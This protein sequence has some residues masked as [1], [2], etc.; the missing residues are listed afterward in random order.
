MIIH[1]SRI[2][3]R[4]CKSIVPN[5]PSV[6]AGTITPAQALDEC[7]KSRI[8]NYISEPCK[9]ACAVSPEDM[10]RLLAPGVRKAELSA[11]AVMALCL[12]RATNS[13]LRLDFF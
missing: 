2:A 7:V 3:V 1:L 13:E 9:E 10:E 6:K 4:T 11:V 8:S 5:L 12:S